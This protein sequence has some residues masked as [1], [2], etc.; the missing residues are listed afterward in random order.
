M[1]PSLKKITDLN[2]KKVILRADINVPVVD[3]EVAVGADWRIRAI[4]PTLN[5]LSDAGAK[6]ILIA[7]LGRP[8]GRDMHFSL[9]PVFCRLKELWSK[10]KIFFSTDVIG[11]ETENKISRLKAGEVLLLENLRFHPEE[12]A[13]EENFSKKLASYGDIFVNDAFADSHRAHASMVGLPKFL[14]SYAGFLLEKEVSMLGLVRA[15]PRQPLVFIMGGAKADT[16]LKLIKEF[17]NK[18][19]AILLGGIL[20]NTILNAK[21]LSVG[22]SLVEE[23]LLTEAK[24]I[25]SVSNN[26]FL[27]AD[28]CV[29]E[30]LARAKNVAVRKIKDVKPEEFVVDIGPETIFSF[31]EIIKTAKMIVWNG[32]VGYIELSDFRKGSLEIAKAVAENQGEK[33]IGGGDLIGFLAEQNLIEKMTYVSTGGGAM[34]EFLAGDELPG[35]KVLESQ[36]K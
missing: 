23:K 24:R 8:Q 2:G 5:Y 17:L 9:Y 30:S 33:I 21:G 12:E 27:P 32:P 22:K 25:S 3:G 15:K 1:L 13:N 7:H 20:A 31:K 29:T 11:Q 14:K 28:V 6:I 4:L 10:D 34:L 18:S 16:K 36:N 19:E 26:L 35:I